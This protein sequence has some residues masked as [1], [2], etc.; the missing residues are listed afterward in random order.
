MRPKWMVDDDETILKFMSEHT[1]PTT[2]QIL[3]FQ[4]DMSYPQIKKRIGILRKH[5]MIEQP[6]EI[7]KGLSARGVYVIT[8]FGRQ[9]L[10]GEITLKDFRRRDPTVNTDNLDN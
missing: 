9:Y 3:A 6:E 10:T 1:A 8:E 7:P 5:G 2:A 4:L